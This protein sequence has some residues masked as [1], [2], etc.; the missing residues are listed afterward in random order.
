M[1]K[2]KEKKEEKVNFYDPVL[3]AFREISLSL[4]KKYL[5]GLEDL[6]RQIEENEK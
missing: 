1:A 2:E 6:K 5:E 3:D 4:A